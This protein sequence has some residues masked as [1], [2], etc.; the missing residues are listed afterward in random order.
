MALTAG[1]AQALLSTIGTV[2]YQGSS[3]NLI[4]DNDSPFGSIVWLDYTHG[5]DT[6]GNQQTWASGLDGM[7][8]VNYHLNPG[9]TMIWDG[10]WRLPSTVDS[11][12]SSGY[13]PPASSSEMAHLY[14][15]ELG[16]SGYPDAGWGLA[17]TGDFTHL[18]PDWY[19]SG[20]EYATNPNGAWTF[21]TNIGFQNAFNLGYNFFALAVRPGHESAAAVPEPSTLLLLGGGLAG[22]VGLRLRRRTR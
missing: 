21:Y 9:V 16:N 19:W 7:G 12:S 5:H 1:S 11:V 6:W 10:S 4:Y 17:N 14:Y 3:Y 18:V 15:T 2:D 13:N 22:M 20:T 8:P